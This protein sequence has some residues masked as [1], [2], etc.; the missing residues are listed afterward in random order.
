MPG[1]IGRITGW[2]AGIFA[3][4]DPS[5]EIAESIFLVD[6]IQDIQ[7][8]QIDAAVISGGVQAIPEEETPRLA[9]YV[10]RKAG[11]AWWTPWAVWRD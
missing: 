11:F 7:V 5:E 4:F 1:I 10:L 6:L 2:L 9:E 3:W 8:Q